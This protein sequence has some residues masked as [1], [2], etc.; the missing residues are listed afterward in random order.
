MVSSS[1]TGV[2]Q[3]L[4]LSSFIQAK[5]LLP[6]IRTLHNTGYSLHNFAL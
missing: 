2:I 6:V 5:L 1:F 4:R 3:M